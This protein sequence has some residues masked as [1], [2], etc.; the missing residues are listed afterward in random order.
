MQPMCMCPHCKGKA[1]PANVV[2]HIQPHRGDSRLFWNPDN[3]QSMNK[4]CHDRYKQSLERGGHGFDQ[5]CDESGVP[6]SD[7]HPWNDKPTYH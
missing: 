5:G 6:L 2:D 7:D 4:Q 1:L 3:L